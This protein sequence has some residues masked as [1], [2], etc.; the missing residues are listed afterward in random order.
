MSC[1]P[2]RCLS[3]TQPHTRHP[4]KPPCSQQPSEAGATTIKKL[5]TENVS[6]FPKVEQLPSGGTGICLFVFSLEEKFYFTF[7]ISIKLWLNS[8][9]A[10]EPREHRAAF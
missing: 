5:S 7:T 1:I 9:T 10:S 4:G 2:D 8:D 3:G 6:S